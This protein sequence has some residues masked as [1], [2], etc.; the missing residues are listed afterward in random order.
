M[1]HTSDRII[2]YFNKI[3][4]IPRCSCHEARLAQWLKSWAVDR[5]WTVLED[6]TGNQVI[7]V[8]ATIGLE[9]AATVVLQGHNGYGLRKNA[10]VQS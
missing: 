10:V 4:D 1:S 7:R 6:A 3:N 2:A 8:P 5:R 9:A